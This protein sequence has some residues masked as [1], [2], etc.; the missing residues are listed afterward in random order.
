M[1]MAI[2]ISINV[3]AASGLR[4]FRKDRSN[5]MHFAGESEIV[6]LLDLA[7]AQNKAVFTVDYAVRSTNTAWVARRS[8]ALGF[9]PF[10]GA[11]SLS[12]YVP[13]MRD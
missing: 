4:A 1:M 5:A 12:A 9:V 11:R 2:K 13:P 8:R 7:R 10:V 6:P 3:N